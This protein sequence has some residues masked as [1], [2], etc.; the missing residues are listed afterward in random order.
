MSVNQFGI[1][2]DI[3][4]IKITDTRYLYI[5]F[6]DNKIQV[7]DK[8]FNLNNTL[9]YDRIIIVGK[10]AS[11]KDYLRNHLQRIRLEKDISIT[12][13]PKRSGEIDGSDYHFRSEDEFLQMINDDKFYEYNKFVDWYYGTIVNNFYNKQLFIMTPE[14]IDKIKKKDRKNSFVIYLDIPLDTRM[15]RLKD[16]D[17]TYDSIERRIKTDDKDFEDID[18]DLR[19]TQL[20]IEDG[21]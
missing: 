13:R 17:M 7:S 9:K 19:I 8:K 3:L 14:G 12:T 1:Q 15:E 10:M 18:Y 11:G 20:K 5:Q 2:K 4:K 16:R 21:E 6:K